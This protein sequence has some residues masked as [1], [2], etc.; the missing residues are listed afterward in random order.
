MKTIPLLLSLTHRSSLMAV[1]LCAVLF[2]SSAVRAEEP[3]TRPDLTGVVRSQ[4][5]APLKDATIFIYTAGPRV[6]AGFL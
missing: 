6:G 2:L 4:S 5:G 1:T 3:A